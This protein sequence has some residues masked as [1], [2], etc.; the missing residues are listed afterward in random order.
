MAQ[1]FL[2]MFAVF[3]CLVRPDVGVTVLLSRATFSSSIET[4]GKLEFL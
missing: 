3:S 2:K 4:I 1:C